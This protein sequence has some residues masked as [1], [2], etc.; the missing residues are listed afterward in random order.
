MDTPILMWCIWREIN[1]RC[2]EDSKRT[3]VDLINLFFK[4]LLDW[5]FIIEI[6]SISSVY[7]LMNAWVTLFWPP[8]VYFQ[9]TWVTLFYDLNKISITN[10]K[11]KKEKKKKVNGKY[12][13]DV[14]NKNKQNRRLGFKINKFQKIISKE[15]KQ[16]SL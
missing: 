11:K 9:Y 7:D 6:P 3:I 13:R 2:F 10:H 8:V 4:K 12:K 5:M 15:L 16:H 1:N 14:Q